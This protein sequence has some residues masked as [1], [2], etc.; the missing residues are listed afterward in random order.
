MR[1]PS[2]A[3]KPRLRLLVF[4]Q[5]GLAMPKLSRN[6]D[7]AADVKT[8]VPLQRTARNLF[9]LTSG[10]PRD[11]LG[12]LAH[13][14][15]GD[16]ENSSH[17]G[18]L[19]PKVLQDISLQHGAEFPIV[20]SLIQEARGVGTSWLTRLP[21]VSGSMSELKDR[22]RKAMGDQLTQA[23]LARA[24]KVT[25]AAVSK[26]LSGDTRDI[27]LRHVTALAKACQVRVAWLVADEGEM[28]EPRQQPDLAAIAQQVS[29]LT[30]MVSELQ[31]PK[32]PPKRAS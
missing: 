9:Q 26:W 19:V 15:A 16:L 27:K 8:L 6:V 30:E 10:V 12:P 28:R 18:G 21:L 7:S 31:H 11:N 22:I 4:K 2:R 29:A 17:R 14:S 23:D 24:C 20:D 1:F 25:R 13:G 5:D 32:R 3:A